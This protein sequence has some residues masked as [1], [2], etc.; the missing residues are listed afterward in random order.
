MGNR[1]DVLA[2]NGLKVITQVSTVAVLDS[3]GNYITVVREPV[4]GA[5]FWNTCRCARGS[6]EVF[7]IAALAFVAL[8]GHILHSLLNH[9]G[10][11]RAT[12]VGRGPGLLVVLL[13]INDRL[14]DSGGSP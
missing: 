11:P 5:K 14:D 4:V 1:R 7:S 8:S 3:A 9:I 12:L 13:E 6:D 2:L 10:A